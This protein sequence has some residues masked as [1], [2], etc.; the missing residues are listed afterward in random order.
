MAIEIVTENEN[1]LDHDQLE[2]NAVKLILIALEQYDD[3]PWET[4]LVKNIMDTL[5]KR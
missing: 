1:T 2:N 3:D 4:A 5:K